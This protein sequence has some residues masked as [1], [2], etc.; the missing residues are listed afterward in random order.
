[1]RKTTFFEALNTWANSM[2]DEPLLVELPL[3]LDKNAPLEISIRH[4]SLHI[5]ATLI[6][7]NGEFDVAYQL[8]FS[9]DAE[10]VA[11]FLKTFAMFLALAQ[12]KYYETTGN[13]FVEKSL[14]KVY[15]TLQSSLNDITQKYNVGYRI[16]LENNKIHV[17]RT[18]K[19][20]VGVITHNPRTYP[21]D[22]LINLLYNMILLNQS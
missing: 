6:I 1:M 3:N 21:L 9:F 8:P 17:Y 5:N 20:F 13:I 4:N 16:F 19:Y 7:D 10:D 12:T 22:I 18:D 11:N 14:A 2:F 15:P